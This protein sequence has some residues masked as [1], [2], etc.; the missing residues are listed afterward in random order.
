MTLLL[1]SLAN[2]SVRSDAAGSYNDVLVAV[3]D[4]WGAELDALYAA[5]WADG[6]PEAWASYDRAAIAASERAL[7]DVQALP[8]FEGDTTLRDVLEASVQLRLDLHAHEIPARN[9]LWDQPTVRWADVEEI[10][11]IQASMDAQNAAMDD[12]VQQVQIAFADRYDLVL[13]PPATIGGFT[14]PPFDAPGLP[15]SDLALLDWERADLAMRFHN[16]SID[17]YNVGIDA[18]NLWTLSETDFD[19]RRRQALATLDAP[20]SQAQDMGPWNAS[21]S[22]SDAT[23]GWLLAVH[24]LLSGPS[25]EL[26][27]LLERR[28]LFPWTRQRALALA[29]QEE[30]TIQMA[31]VEY[32]AQRVRFSDLW[33]LDAYQDWAEGP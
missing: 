15:P 6:T 4:A 9:A 11:A 7:A 28:L 3:H 26:A 29:N 12:R 31:T 24:E 17:L 21:T 23:H 14:P 32:E 1:I 33:A 19:G 2:A 18:L 16:E 25:A 8:G 5:A 10:S 27:G 30:A 13:D 20:L 22:L